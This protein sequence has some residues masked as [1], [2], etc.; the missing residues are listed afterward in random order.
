MFEYKFFQNSIFIDKRIEFYDIVY[1]KWQPQESDLLIH[2]EKLV[3]GRNI[4][5]YMTVSS[6]NIQ[7]ALED[8]C[9]AG[10]QGRAVPRD[11]CRV[12]PQ[13]R[14]FYNLRTNDFIL[15]IP[16]ES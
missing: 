10:R 3:W 9:R 6:I 5:I 14:V 11:G 2:V 16:K 8:V 13:G 1:R 12:G 15:K 7:P 4:E